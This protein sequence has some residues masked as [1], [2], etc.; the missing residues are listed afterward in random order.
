MA[1]FV[2][3]TR[4]PAPGAPVRVAVRWTDRPERISECPPGAFNLHVA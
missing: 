4:R 1:T 2:G 3:L